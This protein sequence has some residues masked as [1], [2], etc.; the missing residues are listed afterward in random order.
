MSFFSWRLRQLVST[1]TSLTFWSVVYMGTAEAFGYD[2]SQMISYIFLSAFL[3]SVIQSTLL[4][5]LADDIYTGVISNM[6]VK[7]VKMFAMWISQEFAD[8]SMNIFFVVCESLLLLWIFK[9]QIVLPDTMH[10]I[11]FLV[12]TLL[13][14]VLLFY[15][16]LLFGTIGFWS[17][18]TW[19]IRFL[20]FMFMDFT[21][22]KLYPLDILPPLGRQI[23][24]L[25]PFPYLAYVQTQLFLGKY[26]PTETL[27]MF[28]VLIGWVVALAL[29]FKVVWN[30]G[31][32]LYGAVGR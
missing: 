16:I 4:N 18:E 8:K 27:Q 24:F 23:L 6:L 26:T 3:Q 5:G 12:A 10:L 2:R 15:I 19:G 11:L 22:G 25:T 7:P 14:A 32:K 13:G 20:F 21:A 30:R 28:A 1:F 17:A 31:L 29:L 9:P